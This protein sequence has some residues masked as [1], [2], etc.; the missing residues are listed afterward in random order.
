[1][2][3]FYFCIIEKTDT[4]KAI[5]FLV[6]DE[7]YSEFYEE[8]ERIEFSPKTAFLWLTRSFDIPVFKNSV[9]ESSYGIAEYGVTLLENES[10]IKLT[11]II[12]NSISVLTDEERSKMDQLFNMFKYA[13]QNDK[14]ICC[15]A[16]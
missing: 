1:M 4:E 5:P 14:F 11:D 10:I 7:I 16:I 13:F 15:V 9:E 6:S 3:K 12:L 2:E 8:D